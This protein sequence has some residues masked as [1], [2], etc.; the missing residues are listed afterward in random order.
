MQNLLLEKIEYQLSTTSLGTWKRFMYP[1][2][3]LYAEFKSHKT[4]F[5]IPLLHYVYGICPATGRRPFA[6]GI[7]AVGR[8]AKG[9]VAIGQLSIG[10][11]AIGQL[12]IGLFA[13]AQLSIAIMAIGQASFGI[14][15][16]IG[17][18]AVGNL[19]IGQFALGKMVLA[20]AG[21]GEHVWSVKI[22]DPSAMEF[23]SNLLERVKTLF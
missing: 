9:V 10:A 18:L 6:T 16:A 19:A 17:Q 21:L 22:K 13:L 7:L 8:K 3:Q 14:F 12:G 1:T 23:F 11:I 4:I 20:Q 5:G 15:L 2:G